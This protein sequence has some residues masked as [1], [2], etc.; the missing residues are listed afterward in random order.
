MKNISIILAFF[1]RNLHPS[2]LSPAD[3]FVEIVYFGIKYSI[4]LLSKIGLFLK[5]TK[6]IL[7]QMTDNPIAY[8]TAWLSMKAAPLSEFIWNRTNTGKIRVTKPFRR[9]LR[10]RVSWPG[11][12]DAIAPLP[13]SS[14]ISHG[15]AF[16]ISF[17]S[18]F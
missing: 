1:A 2:D 10:L 14:R 12:P 8:F 11:F 18:K 6:C 7:L 13:V 9:K 3:M 4:S 16:L 15:A 17:S 5:C